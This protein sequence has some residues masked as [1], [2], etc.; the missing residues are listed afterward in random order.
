[1]D[2]KGRVRKLQ[3]LMA[4][5]NLSASLISDPQDIFYY[6]GYR[7]GVDDHPLLLIRNGRPLLFLSPLTGN[8]HLTYGEISLFSKKNDLLRS[9]P[10]KLGFDQRH[11]PV[12][13]F[14][15]L[16]KKA[17][18]S[19][20]SDTIK[21]PRE[22]K[23][24]E[25]ISFMKEAIRLDKKVLEGLDFFNRNEC[26][27]AKEIEQGF[28]KNGA[29]PAFETIV[30]SGSNAGNYIHHFPTDKKTSRKEMIIVDF[31][32]QVK[33]YSSDIT[34]T[35][36]L[37]GDP[38]QKRI[39]E[40]VQQL[41]Q[42]CIDR[43]RP[44]VDFSEINEFHKKSLRKSGFVPRHGIGHGIGIFVHENASVLE[45]GM[46]VTIEPGIYIKNFGG[47]RIEDMVLVGNKSKVLSASIPSLH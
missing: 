24:E 2:F 11:L 37:K 43:V 29:V 34:R 33:G 27:V 30:A 7:S 22:V 20:I 13:L 18:M 31:G 40:T 42:E 4:E 44:G 14:V 8:V 35:Y 19:P 38:K 28:Y 5:K 3:K 36:F 10:K 45:K 12:A 17:R 47:C 21:K 1:M 6:S 25:E 16:K 9:I 39:F 32:S 26:V 41:Q 23:D 15:K 46:I